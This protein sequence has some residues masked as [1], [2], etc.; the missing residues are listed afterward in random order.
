MLP[1][2]GGCADRPYEA[3]FSGEGREILARLRTGQRK[4]ASR[5]IEDFHHRSRGGSEG[6]LLKAGEFIAPPSTYGHDFME[7]GLGFA[8]MPFL[9]KLSPMQQ[10][11]DSVKLATC[12]DKRC[13]LPICNV[14]NTIG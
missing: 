3:Q 11:K 10:V 13:I 8:P 12:L 14:W 4:A 5:L 9:Q 2:N 1:V 6:E 7:A